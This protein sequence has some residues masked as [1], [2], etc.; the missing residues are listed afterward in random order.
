LHR[1]CV[2][3][4]GAQARAREV[5]SER[6]RQRLSVNRPQPD[7]LVDPGERVALDERACELEDRSAVVRLERPEVQ[8]CVVERADRIGAAHACEEVVVRREVLA[9]IETPPILRLPRD[10]QMAEVCGVALQERDH[11]A[12]RDIAAL[13]IADEPGAPRQIEP[14]AELSLRRGTRER[15]AHGLLRRAAAIL[16]SLWARSAW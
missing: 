2:C 10:E 7:V 5:W 12:C 14:H 6:V 8:R 16:A 11:A 4:G 15:E 1:A 13:G 9:R 3:N